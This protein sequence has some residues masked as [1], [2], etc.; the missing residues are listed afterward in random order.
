MKKDARRVHSAG[1]RAFIGKKTV[2]LSRLRLASRGLTGAARI[3]FGAGVNRTVTAKAFQES[4]GAQPKSLLVE[5]ATT[6]SENCGQ[7]RN[8]P[9]VHGS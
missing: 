1:A 8:H 2:S 7:N 4:L 6:R 5:P 3:A 9:A